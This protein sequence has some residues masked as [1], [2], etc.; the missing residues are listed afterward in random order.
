MYIGTDRIAWLGMDAPVP[1]I[2]TEDYEPDA[3]LCSHIVTDALKHGA[4]GFIADVEAPSP[5]MDTPAYEHFS[6]LGFS[7]PYVRTH[8]TRSS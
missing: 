5:A 4:R 8:Y 2:T 1:G 7:R 3:A 6:K